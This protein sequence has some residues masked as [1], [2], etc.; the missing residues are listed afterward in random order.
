MLLGMAVVKSVNTKVEFATDFG[1]AGYRHADATWTELP[2]L[3]VLNEAERAAV[4]QTVETMNGLQGQSA[5]LLTAAYALA[6]DDAD[7]AIVA[8]LKAIADA[9]TPVWIS[10]TPQGEDHR[11]MGGTNGG[12]LT[13][14][15]SRPQFGGVE[16]I[17][18]GFTASGANMDDTFDIDTST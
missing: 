11:V 15:R 8:A 6:V 16:R 13:V 18:I 4:P 17:V 2:I 7:A 3:K 14:G 12:L 10:E 9:W 1:S 5:E